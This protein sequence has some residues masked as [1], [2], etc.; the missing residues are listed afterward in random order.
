M[1]TRQRVNYE[2]SKDIYDED[3]RNKIRFVMR[4]NRVDPYPGA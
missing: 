2:K 3:M 4:K 1:Q